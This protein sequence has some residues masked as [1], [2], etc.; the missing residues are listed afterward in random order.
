MKYR[1]WVC[2]MRVMN[3]WPALDVYC[4]NVWW[5][6]CLPPARSLFM[7]GY[8]RIHKRKPFHRAGENY[9]HTTLA[10]PIT[11]LSDSKPVKILTRRAKKS[12]GASLAARRSRLMDSLAARELMPL[13]FQL[14]IVQETQRPLLLSLGAGRVFNYRR[15]N[16]RLFFT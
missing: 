2:R 16:R 4:L 9:Y 6:V 1:V 5:N 15:H 7:I 12:L 13:P 14:G 11:P 10:V 8:R 3:N